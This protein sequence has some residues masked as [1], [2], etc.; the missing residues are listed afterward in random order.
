MFSQ[1][2]AASGKTGEPIPDCLDSDDTWCRLCRAEGIGG[3]GGM[4]APLRGKGRGSLGAGGWGGSD[5]LWAVD[6]ETPTGRWSCRRCGCCWN[7]GM[8][9]S[10]IFFSVA[11]VFHKTQRSD[12]SLDHVFKIL[13][14]DSSPESVRAA[15]YFE[16]VK[17][18]HFSVQTC[19]YACRLL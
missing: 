10:W 14:R 12:L 16:N 2:T 9:T 6:P 3:G 13:T 18:K 19:W 15:N 4:A 11:N 7:T 5:C 1:E 8:V 17:K